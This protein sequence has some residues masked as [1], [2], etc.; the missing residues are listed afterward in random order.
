V[1][2][3]TPLLFFFFFHQDTRFRPLSRHLQHRVLAQ[4]CETKLIGTFFFPLR[5]LIQKHLHLLFFLSH[6]GGSSLSVSVI[7]PMTVLAFLPNC[8]SANFSTSF[9]P[10]ISDPQPVNL[11]VKFW[12]RWAFPLSGF[13]FPFFL[14]FSPTREYPQLH[15]G[16]RY[17]FF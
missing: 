17:F 5:R 8:P 13:F 12:H 2:P 9:S 7:F 15:S 1:A 6:R 16:Q 11:F 10:P 4:N 3:P 14:L